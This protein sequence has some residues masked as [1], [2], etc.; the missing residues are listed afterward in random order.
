MASDEQQAV[1]S[2]I[3]QR[4]PIT[5]A[6]VAEEVGRSYASVRAGM[7][8]WARQTKALGITD[9]ATAQPSWPWTYRRRADGHTDYIVDEPVRAA[10]LS[11]TGAA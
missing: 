10:I 7:A 5:C 1:L 6:E 2:Q 4:A 8:A 11:V 9:P 3:A